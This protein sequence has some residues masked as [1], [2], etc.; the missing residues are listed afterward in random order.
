MDDNIQ[1]L[2]LTAPSERL[3]AFIAAAEEEPLLVAIEHLLPPS[4]DDDGRSARGASTS[5]DTSN[6]GDP[7]DQSE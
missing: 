2:L 7:D 3:Q 4:F 5:D 6:P 1:E